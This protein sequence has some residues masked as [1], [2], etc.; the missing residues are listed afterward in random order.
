VVS[1]RPFRGFLALAACLPLAGPL[2]CA[3]RGMEVPSDLAGTAGN[4]GAT[5]TDAGVDRPPGSGGSGGI[6][7]TG[8]AG[9]AAGAG[10][11]SAG[12]GSGGG[13]P[14]GAGGAN[15]GGAGGGNP[16]GSG[17]ASAGGSGGANPGGNGGA[18]AG[19]VGG[20]ANT[21][22]AGGSSAGGGAGT[23]SLGG[24]GGANAGGAGGAAGANA[25]G[26]GGQ[27]L[28]S[29][30]A[31][32]PFDQTAGPAIPDASGNGHNGTLAGTATFPAG[33]IGNG[34]TL[35][36]VSGDYVAL[37]SA[38]LQTVTDVTITLWVNV[39]TDHTWQRIFDFGSSQNVYMFL[40]PHAG[41]GNVAR[42]AITTSGNGNEQRLDAKAVLPLG[43]WTHVAIV[44]GAGGGTLYINGAV[45]ATNAMLALRPADLGATANNWLGRS[46]FAVDP[47]FDGEID[48][49]RVY[50]S[51]LAA[52]QITTIYTAR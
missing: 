13:N 51:A 9:G 40:T 44:L 24:S 38:L 20:Q 42:F 3:N 12:G 15:N 29:P 10:G 25:G 7:A 1:V 39:R 49:L 4:G 47:A 52:S 5:V 50:N 37:P 22:G 41:T 16:G 26:A 36:G 34:L 23:A 18:S 45:V 14:G 11:A 27:A 35:P 31:Y 6:A 17:G 32:Y 48:E 28:P 8:G 19:G 33:V 46:Q 21:G 43:T 30:F 2:A